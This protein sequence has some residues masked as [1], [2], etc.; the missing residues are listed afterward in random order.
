MD[1]ELT[2]QQ[3]SELKNTLRQQRKTLLARIHEVLLQSDSEHY[4]DLSGKVHDVGE[5]AVAA[6]LSDVNLAVIDHEINELRDVEQALSRIDS[7]SYGICIDCSAPIGYE[8]LSAY[9]TAKRCLQCQQL[10]EK[11]HATANKPSL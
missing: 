8:R 1:S 2:P 3:L 10:Y 7:G 6:L 4:V 11:T 5:E 9:P